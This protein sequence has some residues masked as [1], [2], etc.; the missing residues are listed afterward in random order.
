MGSARGD[1]LPPISV[2]RVGGRHVVRDEH[3]RVFVARAMGAEDIDAEVI[4]PRPLTG[5]PGLSTNKPLDRVTP[6]RMLCRQRASTQPIGERRYTTLRAAYPQAAVGIAPARAVNQGAGLTAG[7]RLVELNTPLA[8]WRE[9][10][11]TP[12]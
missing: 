9:Q 6:P 2:H 10:L 7:R 3:H 11:S 12:Y 5:A 4:E 1:S 8:V